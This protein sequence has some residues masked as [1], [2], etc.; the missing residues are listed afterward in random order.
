MFNHFIQ[1]AYESLR[2]GSFN[3]A[4]VIVFGLNFCD[5]GKYQL[6]STNKKL[7]NELKEIFSH[8]NYDRY[9]QEFMKFTNGTKIPVVVS[10]INA[11]IIRNEDK[12]YLPNDEQYNNRQF[13]SRIEDIGKWLAYLFV[14]QN[15]TIPFHQINGLQSYF[16]TLQSNKTLQKQSMKDR[17]ESIRGSLGFLRHHIQKPTKENGLYITDGEKYNLVL[18]YRIQDNLGMFFIMKNGIV[19]GIFNDSTIIVFYNG[20]YHFVDRNE[21]EAELFDEESVPDDETIIKKKRIIDDVQRRFM[22]VITKSTEITIDTQHSYKSS[23][24]KQCKKKK[25]YTYFRFTDGSIHLMFDDSE[26]SYFVHPDNMKIIICKN[27]VQ[28]VECS[29]DNTE[30]KE[31][32]ELVTQH[33]D[34]LEFLLR[35]IISKYDTK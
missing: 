13:A 2:I 20:I 34:I 15:S 19:G 12:K 26:L 3:I 35:S 17:C 22:K 10:H 11:V 25:G 1:I 29:I 5:N 16:E 9:K 6:T 18:Q 4:S 14:L 24:V 23:V 30:V 7:Y 32:D 33:L 8:A 21:T 27:G 28:L 31:H